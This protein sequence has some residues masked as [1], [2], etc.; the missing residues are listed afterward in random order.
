MCQQGC[1][2]SPMVFSLFISHASARL[3]AAAGAEAVPGAAGPCAGRVSHLMFADALTLLALPEECMSRMLQALAAYCADKGMMV[4]V[5]K[6][7]V[8]SGSTLPP[9]PTRLQFMGEDIE[10]VEEFTYLGLPF[11]S[12]LTFPRMAQRWEGPLCGVRAEAYA[13]AKD[14]GVHHNPHA[15]LSLLQTFGFP[16]MMYGCQ[17]WG[18]AFLGEPM[19]FT[20]PLQKIWAQAIRR[21]FGVHQGVAHH[22]LFQE[23]GARPLQFYWLSACV[24]FWNACVSSTNP[25]PP[26]CGWQCV[27]RRL[28]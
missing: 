5:A 9:P 27:V 25:N 24:N 17:I 20:A 3:D 18:A 1:P 11:S 12:R 2:L 14:R 10:M 6:G 15:F 19:L 23:A 16:C 8:F 22:V 21:V 13:L 26:S 28:S 4:H 7:V